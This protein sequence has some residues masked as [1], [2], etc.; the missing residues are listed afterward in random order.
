MLQVLI[1]EIEYYDERENA[2]VE[3]MPTKLTLEHSLLS[4]AKWEAKWNKPFYDLSS[5]KTEEEWLDYIRCMTITQNVDQSIYKAMPLQVRKQIEDYMDQPMTATWFRKEE[6]KSRNRE[7]ITAE[8]IY[9]WMFSQG[10]PLECQKW[11]INRLLTQIR[12]CNEKNRESYDSKRG[13]RR[14]AS[15]KS[16]SDRKSLNQRRKERLNSKG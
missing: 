14:K 16:I 9:W 13:K 2:F 10:I 8:I 6:G 1:P 7:I 5:D 12:V 4:I 15:R 11:H 3:I